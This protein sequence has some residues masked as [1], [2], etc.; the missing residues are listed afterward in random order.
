MKNLIA[1]SLLLS[2]LFIGF[3]LAE[4]TGQ[5]L[6]KGQIE[7]LIIGNT[8]EGVK[9][10]DVISRTYEE[11]T[12]R[13]QTYYRDDG[14][15]IQKGAGGGDM[16][17][18]TAEGKWWVKKHAL[19]YQYPHALRERGEICRK[20]VPVGNGAYELQ[21]GRGETKQIWKRVVEGN[22]HKL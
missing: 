15:V 17:G 18:T 22:P 7:A 13:F 9:T 21:T 3:A 6:K 14:V 10:R 4:Q 12:I 16:H 20:V 1:L 11:V 5:A 19:C 2:F 8:T